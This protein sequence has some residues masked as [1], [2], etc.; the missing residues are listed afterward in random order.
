MVS[1]STES[2]GLWKSMTWTSN[3]RTAEPGI[4]FPG[5]QKN[6]RKNEKEKKSIYA[7]PLWNLADQRYFAALYSRNMDSKKFQKAH[8]VTLSTDI[9]PVFTYYVNP[10]FVLIIG[11]SNKL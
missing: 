7:G 9:F 11:L 4:L 1:I 3:I 2:V 6:A 5:I 8:E 10:L